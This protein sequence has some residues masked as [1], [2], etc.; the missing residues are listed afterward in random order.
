M[1]CQEQYLVSCGGG[2]SPWGNLTANSWFLILLEIIV[3]KAEDK[4]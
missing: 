1:I 3:D 4:R 2:L